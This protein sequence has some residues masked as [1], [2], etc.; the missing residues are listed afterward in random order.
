MLK[1]V[2]SEWSNHFIEMK[3]SDIN[4]TKLDKV[5]NE[6]KEMNFLFAGN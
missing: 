5:I 3:E 2:Y 4:R 6:F 1:I